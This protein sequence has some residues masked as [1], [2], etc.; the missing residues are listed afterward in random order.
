MEKKILG[1]LLLIGSFGF[2]HQRVSGNDIS[3]KS[4]KEIIDQNK[5]KSIPE[6]LN[7][8]PTDLLKN[9]T[10]LYE[11]HGLQGA[12]FENPRVVLFG[13]DAK[14]ILTFNGDPAQKRY[15]DLEI[16]EFDDQSR[17]FNLSTISFASEQVVYSES[18]PPICL[19]CHGDTPRPIWDS[20]NKWHGAFG[21]QDDRLVLDEL[22]YFKDFATKKSDHPRYK[23]LFSNFENRLFPFVATR[24]LETNIAFVPTID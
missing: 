5:I 13:S 20:Y 7:I 16:M 11:P 8:L 23:Y 3:L 14:I 12:S 4:L 24:T 2:L 9:Y 6:V 18:N 19:R 15:S 17:S 22:G 10:M 21:S 1:K